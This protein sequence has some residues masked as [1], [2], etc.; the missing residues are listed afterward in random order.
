MPMPPIDPDVQQYYA[1]SWNEDG[2]IRSGLNEIE[3]IRTREI[4]ERYLP[5]SD[6]RILDVGGASGIHAEWLLEAGH[7]VHLIDPVARH[8]DEAVQKLGHNRRFTAELGDA[9]SLD[10][11]DD[12]FDAVLLFGPLYHL[13]EEVDRR[14]TWTEAARVAMDGGVVFGAVITRFASLFNGLAEGEIFDPVFRRMVETDLATGNH[15]NP[16]GRQYFTTA[17]FHRPE[18]AATEAE[19]AGLAVEAVLGVEGITAWIPRLERSWDDPDARRVIVDAARAIESEPS[20]LGLGP[21]IIIVARPS[22]SV[23]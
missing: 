9:R 4:A 11:E 5:A 13:Q 8:V 23:P 15:S 12:S 18:E 17:Y 7:T 19:Q 3:L 20:L 2:R 14:A 16:D 6:L 21:H 1:S 22:R 10:V